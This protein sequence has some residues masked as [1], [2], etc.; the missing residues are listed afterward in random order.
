LLIASQYLIEHAGTG[1]DRCNAYIYV[2]DV[3]ALY[4]KVS[5]NGQGTIKRPM[6]QSLGVRESVIIDPDN[7]RITLGQRI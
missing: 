1:T 5:V 2:G 7:H 3:D 4:E 6:T